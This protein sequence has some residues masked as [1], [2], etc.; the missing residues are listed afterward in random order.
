M[1]FHDFWIGIIQTFVI[2]GFIYYYRIRTTK[3]FSPTNY[4]EQTKTK[5]MIKK[6]I[7]FHKV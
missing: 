3:N 6:L 4:K 1:G 2:D 5:K 7:Y